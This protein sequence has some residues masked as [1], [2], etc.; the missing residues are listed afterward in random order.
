MRK[1]WVVGWSAIALATV[2]PSWAAEPPQARL[3]PTTTHLVA[4]IK[5]FSE[6]DQTKDPKSDLAEQLV[7]LKQVEADATVPLMD[8]A[9]LVSNIGGSYFYLRDYAT[10]IDWMRRSAAMIEA[11]GGPPEDVAGSLSNQG[12]ILTSLGRL[13]EAEA[14]HRRALEIRQKI[15]GPRGKMVSSSLFGLSVALFRMG[16]MEEALE[17]M[18]PA[19]EQQLEF[20]GPNQPLTIMR[21]AS[22]ASVLGKSGRE[23]EAIS[24]ARQ[25]EA[26]AREHLGLDHP[27]YAIALNNL[28]TALIENGLFVEALPVLR[29]TLRVRRATI[30]DK[31]SGTAYSLR[32]LSTALKRTGS[33][34]E[35]EAVLAEGTRILEASGDRENLAALPIMYADLA[36]Y[37]WQRGDGDAYE[38]WS[39]KAISAADAVL[40]DDNYDRAHVHLYRAEKRMLA[41]NAMAALAIATR[42]VPVM[43]TKLIANHRDRLWAEMLLLR[44]QQLAGSGGAMLLTDAD[45]VKSR[46]ALPLGDVAIGDSQLA[47]DARQRRNALVLYLDIAL[48]ANSPERAFEALQLV[49][50]NDLSLGQMIGAN[51]GDGVA[52]RDRRA[53]LDLAR[54]VDELRGREASAIETA[55]AAEA[56]ALGKE[57]AAG[58]TQLADARVLFVRNHPDFAL[59]L[60]PQPAALADALRQLAPGRIILAPVEADERLRVLTIDRNG[61]R[62]SDAPL[63]PVREQV[64]AIRAAV[65]EADGSGDFPFA[66]AGAL[67]QTLFP[68]GLKRGDHVSLYGGGVLASVPLGLLTNNPAYAGEMA[69]APW[70][71]RQAVFDVVSRPLPGSPSIARVGLERFVGI[72]G[73]AAP[74]AKPNGAVRVAALFRSGRPDLDSIAALAPLPEAANELAAMAAAFGRGGATVLLGNTSGEAAIKAADLSGAAVIAFAT[75]GL[76]AGEVRGLWEP[77]L[78]VGRSSDSAEDGLLGASE[79]ARLRLSADLVIL[80]ACNTAAG[81]NSD[82]PVYSGLA[83]AFSQA[84]ARALLLSHWRVR[85][86]AAARLSVDTVRGSK[87]RGNKGAALR[88]AQLSLMSDRRVEHGAHPAIWAPFVVVEP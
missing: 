82:A 12:T 48:A 67:G 6:K 27:T 1:R 39:D 34:D 64:A 72:G 41:G 65:E 76:V 66:A 44:L 18:R 13:A 45:A 7:L 83:T 2:S 56:V 80:S 49:N 16:R 63:A 20:S 59:R 38:R 15:E 40:G 84:G 79:I 23:A 30:G 62:A 28:G 43:R 74:D 3:A 4:Q 24:V 11:A 77:A 50:I 29:E 88:A 87:R 81:S 68:Q 85:D 86:D 75:H 33:V 58:Q 26:L 47:R 61:L 22:L 60:R 46:I 36:D 51:Q 32:N 9:T 19:T 10:A 73:P 42:W 71:I 52:D 31:A 37:G 55:K 69:S 8:Q 5:A 53:L 25:G 17:Y 70:L 57:L 78:L 54:H 21:L 14:A 35:G